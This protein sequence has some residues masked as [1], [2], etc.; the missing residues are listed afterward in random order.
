MGSGPLLAYFCVESDRKST[1]FNQRS[2]K[3][4]FRTSN[5]GIRESG[6]RFAYVFN[7]LSRQPQNTDRPTLTALRLFENFREFA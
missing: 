1:G 4:F 2:A 6:Q 7:R 3:L 5:G